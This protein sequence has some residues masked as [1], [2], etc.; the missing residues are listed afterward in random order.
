MILN[1]LI[2]QNYGLYCG[3][4]T[5]NLES[6]KDKNII[7]VGGKNGSGKTTIFDAIRLCLYGSQISEKSLTKKQYENFLINKIH[8]NKKEK[9]NSASI[10]LEFE[11]MFLGKS[12]KYSIKRE[13]FYENNRLEE[14]FEVKKDGKLLEEIGENQWQEFINDLLPIGLSNLFF[15]DGEKIQNLADDLIDNTQLSNSFKALLGLDLVEKLMSDLE[16]YSLKQLKTS[17]MK[18]L[19]SKVSILQ[20]AEKDIQKDLDSSLQRK[21]QIVSELDRLNNL[22]ERQENLISKEG[23]NYSKK[24]D[25]LM[26][27]KNILR[28]EINYIE[29]KIREFCS[30]TLPFT[31]APKLSEKLQFSLTKEENLINQK[32][33]NSSLK[34]NLKK[35]NQGVES[36]NFHIENLDKKSEKIIKEKIINLVN[37]F[38]PK[39]IKYF[40]KVYNLSSEENI[41]LVNLINNI[42]LENHKKT[43]NYFIDLEK[44]IK[45]LHTIEKQLS[46]ATEDSILKPFL[47]VIN[48]LNRNKGA[49]ESEYSRIEEEISTIRLKHSNISGEIRKIIDELKSQKNLSKKL[50]LVN[51]TQI[52]LEEY[53]L[54]LKTQKLKEFSKIFIE[55]FN[56]LMRKK[57]VFNKIDINHEDYSVTLYKKGNKKVPKSS[58][59]AGEKQ[60]YAISMLWALTKMSRRSLP[61][62]IDTPLGRLDKEH[63]ENIIKKFFPYASEQLIILSTDTEVT[64]E[65]QEILKSKI[66]NSLILECDDEKT[67]VM[68]GYF[69]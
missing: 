20:D 37:Y 22:I 7:L 66:N 21:S 60:L 4:N 31:F 59:S 44:K 1:K 34:K 48:S 16:I 32:L 64:K 49:L 61:F 53:Y 12:E 11:H 42:L 5:F 18:D 3:K 23:G 6:S 14:F 52:I 9:F 35:I 55:L 63:R 30:Q 68:E 43:K 8:H 2:L 51:K 13:W 17:G 19:N 58:L 27:K 57:D 50:K 46:F 62:I 45:K 38:S 56:S 54:K 67:K 24:R 47:D 65:Y 41:E 33:S 10:L 15:F 29:D 26:M 69:E 36:L 25:S 39:E 28:T 40:K